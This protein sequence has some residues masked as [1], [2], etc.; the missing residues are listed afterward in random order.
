MRTQ[1]IAVSARWARRP[2][3][4]RFLAFAAALDAARYAFLGAGGLASSGAGRT[5]TLGWPLFLAADQTWTVALDYS[6]A[7][8]MHD[9]FVGGEQR[10][11]GVYGAADNT[12]VP[13]AN[14][15]SCFAGTG[16]IVF[17]GNGIG[18]LMIFR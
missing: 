9:L 8:F 7:M 13:A 1:P 18:T 16:R 14:R 15:L 2:A 6:G 4:F 5:Y 3:G 12:S 11:P 10:K 17:L